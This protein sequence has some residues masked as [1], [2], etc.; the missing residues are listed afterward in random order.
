MRRDPD[1]MDETT[2][3]RL[4]HGSDRSLFAAVVR[5][6]ARSEQFATRWRTE[7]DVTGNEHQVLLQLI[8]HGP[9]K[10]A[11]LSRRI[12]VTTASMTAIVASLERKGLVHRV[13]DEHDRRSFLLYVT[14]QALASIAAATQELDDRLG[15]LTANYAQEDVARALEVLDGA[16]S[17][18]GELASQG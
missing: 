7:M 8:V 13:A 6:L 14:K 9:L 5:L 2:P 15:R 3:H 17:A 16:G 1:P 10:S 18:I 12:G 4:P 11:E